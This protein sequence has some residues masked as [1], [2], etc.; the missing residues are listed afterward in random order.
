MDLDALMPP[1]PAANNNRAE[2]S[3]K[4]NDLPIDLT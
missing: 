4:R 2:K 3:A 1:Q